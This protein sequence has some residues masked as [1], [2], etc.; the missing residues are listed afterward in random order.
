MPKQTETAG[1]RI[2]LS[3]QRIPA[4]VGKFKDQHSKVFRRAAKPHRGLS[5]FAKDS[6]RAHQDKFPGRILKDFNEENFIKATLQNL[7]LTINLI[8]CHLLR[9]F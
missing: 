5:E 2:S 7:C 6:G 8:Y 9:N 3:L 1:T 4:V